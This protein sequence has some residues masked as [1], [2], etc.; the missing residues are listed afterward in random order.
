[1]DAFLDPVF[2]PEFFFD[3]APAREVFEALATQS[4]AASLLDEMVPSP[5]RMAPI[6]LWQTELWQFLAKSASQDH[7]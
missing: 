3:L 7:L 5:P 6:V 2:V 1:M 4:A